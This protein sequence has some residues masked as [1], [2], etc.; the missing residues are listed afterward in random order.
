MPS[1]LSIGGFGEIGEIMVSRESATIRVRVSF[2]VSLV[3]VYFIHL[4]SVDGTI[5][6][7]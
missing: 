2:K 4:Y 5:E 6:L 3:A 1:E 7:P